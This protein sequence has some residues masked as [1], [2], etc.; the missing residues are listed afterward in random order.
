MATEFKMSIAYRHYMLNL[1]V[2]SDS[3]LGELSL[4]GMLVGDDY[5]ILN[6]AEKV[7]H[8]VNFGRNIDNMRD[9]KVAF[10]NFLADGG[11]ALIDAKI[12]GETPVE[13]PKKKKPTPRKKK[14]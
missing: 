13:E 6:D 14:A 3:P 12:A 11:S 9:A 7:L 2:K 4:V 5:D 1:L 8:L 10:S